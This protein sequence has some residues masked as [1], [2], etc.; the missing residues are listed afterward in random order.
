VMYRA[1][2]QAD[3]HSHTNQGTRFQKYIGSGT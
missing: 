3:L 2:R 1:F